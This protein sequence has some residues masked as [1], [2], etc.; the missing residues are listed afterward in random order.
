MTHPPFRVALLETTLDRTQFDCGVEPLNDY[1]QHR[2]PQDIRRRVTSCF[3][4][5]ARDGNIAGYYTLGSASL[6]LRDL[7][8]AVTKKLPR[9]PTVP[10]VR[11]ERLAVDLR[12][13]G[14]GLGGA[15]LA[16]ALSRSATSEITAYALIVEAKS[17]SAAAFYQHHGF[18]AL[19]Q[20]EQT[21]QTLFL[22][23][24]TTLRLA[25]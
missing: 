12:Y 23:L 15:L 16:D 13:K 14:E 7:P 17:E 10:V 2:V 22:P 4:A 3:V 9:Y 24:A 19:V 5:H 25:S 21:Q 1:F 6:L 18:M 20:S 11:M 8:P